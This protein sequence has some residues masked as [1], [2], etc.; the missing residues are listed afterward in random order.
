MSQWNEN[1]AKQI[2]HGRNMA[3]LFTPLL[4]VMA[5]PTVPF[6]PQPVIQ[7]PVIP[8]QQWNVR[9]TTFADEW[10]GTWRR[11]SQNCHFNVFICEV[12]R[13]DHQLGKGPKGTWKIKDIKLLN[14]KLNY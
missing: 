1:Q 7:Q 5:P 6:P 12:P 9:L 11:N 13:P 10:G 3:E 8:Q 2:V 14:I 4:K